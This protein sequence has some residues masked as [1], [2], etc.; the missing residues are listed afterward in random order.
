MSFTEKDACDMLKAGKQGEFINAFFNAKAH[1]PDGILSVEDVWEDAIKMPEWGRRWPWPSLDNL[2]YGRR[3]GEGIFVGA[4]VKGGKTEWLS[5]MVHHICYVEN[6]KVLLFKFEQSHGE[7]CKAIAGKA[8][9]K[10]FSKPD[11]DFTQQELINAVDGLKDRIL[12]FDA[13]Y[14]DAGQSN[15]WDRMKAAIRYA[16]LIEGVTDVFL[17][18]ITQITDGLTAAD[19]DVEL[20]RFSNELAALSQKLG[21]FYYCF[22]HLKAPETGKTHE[23]GGQVK[24]AQFRGSRAMAEKTKYMLGIMRDQYNDDPVVRN[25]STFHLLLNSG[26][27][28]TGKFDVFYDD[29]TGDYLEP[30]VNLDTRY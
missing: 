5:Q 13:S 2:T 1:V 7:T 6:K 11:G 29:D 23:E 30:V 18:P 14:S 4:A 3:N 9:N 12:M 26:F 28:K 15:L 19:T 10:R 16:V 22:C 27:G 24:V 20:R 17:D 8:A 21:F 25:T